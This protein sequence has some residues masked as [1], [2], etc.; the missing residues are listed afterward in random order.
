[1]KP[2]IIKK[3]THRL[4]RESFDQ[5]AL[6]VLQKLKDAGYKAYLVGGCIRDLLLKK[7]PKDFDISTSLSPKRSRNSLETAF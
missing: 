6:K 3:S 5:D 7:Q 1:M 2:K 4:E